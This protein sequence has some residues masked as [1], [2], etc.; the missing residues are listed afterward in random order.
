AVGPLLHLARQE[1]VGGARVANSGRAVTLDLDARTGQT[2]DRACD[3]GLIHRVKTPSAELRQPRELVLPD[4]G[5]QVGGSRV[6]VVLEAR[7]EEMLLE[8]D[9]PDHAV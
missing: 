2:K 9:F 3:T 1:I 5:R 6:P 8:G 7:T 4:G